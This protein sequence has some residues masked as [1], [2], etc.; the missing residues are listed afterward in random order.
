MLALLRNQ[1]FRRLFA[2]QLI[3]LTGTGLLTVALGLLAYELAGGEA[4]AVLGTALAIKMVAYVLV[5]PIAGA[6]A[7]QLPRRAM[8][9]GLDLIR[10]GAAIC[11]PFIDAV[12]QIYL[13]IFV[14]QSASG[15]FTPTFQAVIPDILPDERDYTKAL[16]LSRLAYDLETLLSPLLAA[17]LLTVMS[18]HNL[19]A[20][21]ALGFLLS[22]AFVLS[23]RLPPPRPS[24]HKRF[25][26][27]LGQGVR[28]Y[29]L[30]P[31]LRGLL[32]LNL[33]AAAGGAIVF[34]N[35]VVIVRDGLGL[36]DQEVA[37]AL[38]AFGFGSMAAAFA[39]P[40]ILEKRSD[41]TVMLSA[42]ALMAAPMLAAAL[43]LWQGR[44]TAAWTAILLLWPV[45]GAA[46]AAIVT[47]VGRLL[48]RSAHDEDRPDLFAAQFALSHACW[49]LTYPSAGWLGSAIGQP[50]IIAIHAMLAALAAFLASRLW[51]AD[52]AV[53]LAHSHPDLSASHPHLREYGRRRHAHIFVIDDLHRRWPGS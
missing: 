53:I 48:R 12:W 6:V 8:L 21:T 5:A 46:Y 15:A 51:P 29:L 32:A 3:A 42:A 24:A 50:A 14:L 9:I 10:A 41:R 37:I 11:L 44:G 19:F 35:S 1:T 4:G 31:R 52:D 20:G 47:P 30:T 36:G 17:A 13:L 27:R 43:I 18:F 26:D 23:T 45:L 7:G 39:L 25:A 38:A 33:A 49:L 22:A 34:V 28:I 40:P 2:A 16:S